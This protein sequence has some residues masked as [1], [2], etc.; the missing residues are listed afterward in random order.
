MGTRFKI[1]LKAL[2]AI[3]ILLLCTITVFPQKDLKKAFYDKLASEDLAA[4]DAEI[5]KLAGESSTLNNAYAGA[6]MMK[7]AGLLKNP[8][9]KLKEFKSG[10][11]KLEAAISKEPDNAE[12]RLLRLLTQEKAPSFLGY[13][14]NTEEDSRFLRANFKSLDPSV[15]KVLSDYS[16]TS[17]ILKPSD[18]QP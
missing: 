1:Y 7:K 18:F 15:Q 5:E 2:S 16:K 12:F 8:V 4:I 17:S 13:N 10:R 14:K 11:E 6:L 9:N 3:T